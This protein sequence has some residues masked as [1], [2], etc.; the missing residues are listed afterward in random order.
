MTLKNTYITRI[1]FINKILQVLLSKNTYIF[2]SLFQ[3]IEF[4]SH[5]S[6]F[7]QKYF[8]QSTVKVL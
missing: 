2:V 4:K 3:Y 7:I 1:F 5:V 6:F 8:S